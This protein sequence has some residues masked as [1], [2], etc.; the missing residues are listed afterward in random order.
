MGYMLHTA[1]A[2]LE[3]A[4]FIGGVCTLVIGIRVLFPSVLYQVYSLCLFFYGSV[5]RDSSNS[6]S[7]LHAF[8]SYGKRFKFGSWCLLLYVPFPLK[9]YYTSYRSF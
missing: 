1:T 5:E 3:A 8:V 4:V 9:M 6:P 2:G 7:C